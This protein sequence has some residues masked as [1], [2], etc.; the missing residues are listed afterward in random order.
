MK[1]MK[2]V[3]EVVN[4]IR[5]LELY[6]PKISHELALGHNCAAG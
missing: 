2:S 1:E 4:V 6:D 5:I 3:K